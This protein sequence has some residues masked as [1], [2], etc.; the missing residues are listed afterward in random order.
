MLPKAIPQ[1]GRSQTNASNLRG[2][3]ALA[4]PSYDHVGEL[5]PDLHRIE[6]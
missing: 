2:Q 4:D 3:V 1:H 6:L 5:D